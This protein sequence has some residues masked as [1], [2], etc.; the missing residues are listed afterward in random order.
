MFCYNRQRS[1]RTKDTREWRNR[2]TRTFE[3]RVV[4]PYGFKSR[5]SHQEDSAR[6]PLF[7]P[8]KTQ[9]R[10]LHLVTSR[11]TMVWSNPTAKV[12]QKAETISKTKYA[13][14]AE[15][16]SGQNSASEQRANE[17]WAPQESRETRMPYHQKLNMR[18]WRNWQTR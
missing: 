3:G 1:E 6:N 18:V 7:L 14:M 13:G 11:E 17:F 4:I 10:F 2:Q 12:N 16:R 5:L 8:Q 9:N 15:R